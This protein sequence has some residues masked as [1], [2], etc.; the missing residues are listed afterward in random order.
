MRKLAQ[1]T[2]VGS[3]LALM[4]SAPPHAQTARNSQVATDPAVPSTKPAGLAPDEVMKKL[5][6]LVHAGNTR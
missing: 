4:V 1:S 2:I 6:D 3:L 5:S